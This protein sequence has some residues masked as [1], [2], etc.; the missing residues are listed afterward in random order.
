V[1]VT[2]SLKNKR[3]RKESKKGVR[4]HA[5]FTLGRDSKKNRLG[6]Q[7][8]SRN[9][10]RFLEKR[11]SRWKESGQDQRKEKSFQNPTEGRAA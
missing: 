7:D 6:K 2:G 1:E 9:E 8:R 11:F 3:R 4:H 10:L 5:G